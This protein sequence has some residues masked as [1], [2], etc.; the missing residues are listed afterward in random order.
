MALKPI[1][2]LKTYFETGDVPTQQQFYDWLESYHH[3]NDGLIVTSK[4][5]L[6]NGDAKLVFND[7]SELIIPKYVLP[8]NMP[9]SFIDG[10]ADAL[11]GIPNPTTASNGLTKMGDNIEMSGDLTKDT[12]FNGNTS[13]KFVL[14][15]L[16]EFRAY[17]TEIYLEGINNLTLSSLNVVIDAP[18]IKLPQH[19]STRNDGAMPHNKVLSTDENGA[20]KMYEFSIKFNVI[21]AFIDIDNGNDL[22]GVLNNYDLPFKTIDAVLL[23]YPNFSY[24]N[25][26]LKIQIVKS[27]NYEINEQAPLMNIEFY[28]EEFVYLDFSNNPYLRL[29]KIYNGVANY[30][31]YYNLRNGGIVNNT[32]SSFNLRGSDERTIINLKSIVWQS[33]QQIFLDISAVEKLEYLHTKGRLGGKISTYL[34][35]QELK[36]LSGYGGALTGGT[37]EITINKLILEAES[38]FL[39]NNNW[40]FHKITG[41]KPLTM[42]YSANKTSS[43]RFNNTDLSQGFKLNQTLGDITLTGVITNVDWKGYA[44]TGTLNLINL[45]VKNSTGI[46]QTYRNVSFNVINSSLKFIGGAFKKLNVNLQTPK[47]VI[48]NSVI[49]QITPANLVEDIDGT[50]VIDVVQLKTTAIGLS[51]NV[52]STIVDNTHFNDY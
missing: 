19:P 41:T 2:I 15:A 4:E 36:L 28:S 40:T 11:N 52:I 20:L 43:I 34:H 18:S 46:L 21:T 42:H 5:I 12:T 13:F 50:F 17:A 29:Q 39:G 35:L 38:Y 9:I 26:Y 25:E 22:T 32:N 23:L 51:N 48:R 27:G 31:Y 37:I 8:T 33:T 16:K 10:L 7:N 47:I 24:Y 45:V 14:S 49:E 1:D 30:V 44:T 6:A 3:L